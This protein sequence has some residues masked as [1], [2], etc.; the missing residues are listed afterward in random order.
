M[1]KGQPFYGPYARK[2]CGGVHVLFTDRDQ[3]ELTP[4]QFHVMDAVRKLYP[5]TKLF[6]ANRDAMFDKVCG[7]DRIRRMFQEGRP[8]EE[9]LAFWRQGVDEFRTRRTEYLLYD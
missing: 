9:I 6:G 7:T 2:T 5:E 3:A 1:R 4:I 8:I